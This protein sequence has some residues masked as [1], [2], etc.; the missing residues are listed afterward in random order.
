MAKLPDANV[1]GPARFGT[2]GI[3]PSVDVSGIGR[4]QAIAG[5]ALESAGRAIASVG[6]AIDS[7][8]AANEKMDFLKAESQWNVGKIEESTK[9][10]GDQKYEDLPQ[11][12]EQSLRERRDSIAATITNPRAREIFT[13]KTEDDIAR[14]KV[15]ALGKAK[16]KEKDANLAWLD[17]QQDSVINA[18]VSEADP[19][20]RAEMITSHRA[21]IRSFGEKYGVS[22]QDLVKKD[23][24]FKNTFAVADAEAR[25]RRGDTDK[26][27]SE[28]EAAALNA[29]NAPA[30]A[31]PP[32]RLG[33]LSAK[34]ES[35]GNPAA[36]GPDNIGWAYGKHQFN[37]RGSLKDFLS[38]NP[39][40]AKK[41]SGLNPESQAFAN[42]WREVAKEMGPQFEEAQHQTFL[43]HARPSMERATA[44]GFKMEDRG[45]VESVLSG[46]IQHGKWPQV[47][48]KAASVNGFSAMSAE[49][50]VK[51]LYR[52]RVDYVANL[53]TLDEG[54]RAGVLSRFR[55]EIKDALGMV[56]QP[57]GEQAPVQV[58]SADPNFVPSP[59]QRPTAEAGALT[60]TQRA[61]TVY[62]AMDALPRERLLKHMYQVREG[63]QRDAATTALKASTERREEYERKMLDASVGKGALPAREDIEADPTLNPTH[64]NEALRQ[65]GTYAKDTLAF[66]SAFDRFT[67]G[68]SFNP[69]ESE[70]RKGADRIFKSMN[71]DDAA[72]TAIIQR[73][74]ILPESAA[75]KMRADL[76][77]N[78]PK[79][80]AGAMTR[81]SN[82]LSIN[83]NVM[84]GFDGASDLE[85]NAV[86]FRTF[87][88]DFGLTAEEAASRMVREQTPEFK[89]SVNAKLKGENI[90][91]LIK[92]KVTVDD[93]A[94]QFDNSFL[95]L[96]RNP[97][98]GF[99]VRTRDAMFDQFASLTK[100]HYLDMASGDL[101]VAKKLAARDLKKTWGVSSVNGSSTV[102]Q[103]PPER[104]P[105]YH[106]IPDASDRF[107]MH[108]IEAIKDMTGEDVSRA[109]LRIAP[110]PGLTA[111]A[112]KSGGTPPYMVAWTDKS[113]AIQ[114]LPPGKALMVEP[115]EMRSALTEERRVKF[116]QM[117]AASEADRASGATPGMI[118]SGEFGPDVQ[119]GFAAPTPAQAAPQ[120]PAAPEILPGVGDVAVPG[121]FENG[122]P[123]LPS[124]EPQKP[125]RNYW[126]DM[127]D[128][129]GG[130]FRGGAQ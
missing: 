41:F 112:Y 95:G 77:S 66:K 127:R 53:G 109:S 15:A 81:A 129:Q 48:A 34:Y 103:Y 92:K 114:F 43:K 84:T 104:A 128:R 63:Q 23:G 126:Q 93:M 1:L 61:P 108:A 18:L 26:V 119:G 46:S 111:Q 21:L 89:A 67:K 79:R 58:A 47:L 120:T 2:S 37:S 45:V 55:S 39:E 105:A 32:Q 12:H 115:N 54:T 118:T 3:T 78:D 80:V 88:D 130:G 11:R 8:N 6:S 17:E 94:S 7:V 16:E 62:D 38:D 82:A 68:E 69:Y 75:T 125:Y 83:Q 71:S 65:W 51:T 100:E 124:T 19:A 110:V 86:K 29:G 122:Q 4:G 59:P 13:L 27:I 102:M 101:D 64:K 24:A 10:D 60:Q 20:K 28:L 123:T 36:A 70:D 14:S 73:T 87:V 50:Q 74:G 56:G 5:R 35:K 116:E 33:E 98:V 121:G 52:A 49:D 57:V 85:K 91:D 42:R 76:I 40:I 9:F 31:R 96:A 97:Q 30:P 107:A 22:Q 44:L 106:G 72:L 117:R 113:G 99:S 90:D 25:A